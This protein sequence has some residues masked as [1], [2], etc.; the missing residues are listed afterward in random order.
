M[1]TVL[2]PLLPP[3]LRFTVEEFDPMGD[4]DLFEGRR[5]MLLDGTIRKQGPINPP[6]A[7]APREAQVHLAREHGAPGRVEPKWWVRSQS[8]LTIPAA[9]GHTFAAAGVPFDLG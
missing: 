9:A 7:I 4:M 3:P 2:T 5:A 6:H 1:S 8:P